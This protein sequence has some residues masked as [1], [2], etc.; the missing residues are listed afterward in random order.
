MKFRPILGNVF[1]YAMVL[2]AN[3]RDLPPPNTTQCLDAVGIW[4]RGR[5]W[6]W[7]VGRWWRRLLLRL[8]TMLGWAQV[9]LRRETPL[10]GLPGVI[11]D[12]G[13]IHDRINLVLGDRHL[14]GSG[15]RWCE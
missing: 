14:R 8:P 15:G 2:K 6:I 4:R 11:E 10:V 5:S 7:C 12:Q 9:D 13:G 3:R 1:Y